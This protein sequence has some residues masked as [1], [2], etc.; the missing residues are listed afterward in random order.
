MISTI[1]QNAHFHEK[2]MKNEKAHMQLFQFCVI[3]FFGVHWKV[4]I[5][6]MPFWELHGYA[7]PLKKTLLEPKAE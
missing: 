2:K 4:D 6:S 7:P 5:F 1:L 3:L